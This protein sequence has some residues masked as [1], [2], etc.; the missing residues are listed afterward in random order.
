MMGGVSLFDPPPRRVA[1]FR[2]LNLGDLLCT[3]PA[4]RALRE[5]LPDASIS[6]IGLESARPVVARFGQY[7]D[8]L[9]LFP[10]DPAFPEQAV[11]SAELPDFYR[12]MAAR[13]FDLALQWHGS[14]ARSN[15]IVEAMAPRRWGGFVPDIV[16]EQ[17][18][19]L[20]AWPD[21]MPEIRRYLAQLAYM[22][23]PAA[24]DTLEFPLAATDEAEAGAVAQAERMVLHRSV[25]IHP[26]ARLASRRW[27]LSRY[28]EVARALSDDGWRIALTGSKDEQSLASDLQTL[29]GDVGEPVTNLCGKT[30]L[31][32]LAVLLRRGRL[33]ICNDTG[34]SHVAAAVGAP[35][36]VVASGSD[37][38]RWAPTNGR[39]HTVLHAPMAC[40]PCAHD[41]CPI[42]HPCAY[43]VTT[44][45][46]L[47]HARARLGAEGR[48]IPQRYAA[49]AN[50]PVAWHEPITGA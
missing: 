14:G 2:A 23:I 17:P 41:V 21:S 8:E 22:G 5:A 36:V 15:A 47:S 25:F 11:R 43:G 33:L 34:I 29:I 12:D 48:C 30:S 3:V 20:M 19:R 27:P 26:G 46:V 10:G 1:V 9:I 31:G 24:D 32:A 40:R 28:A 6:L 13:D 4:F 39:L 37:V 42:G 18:G 50:G 44:E 16:R 49:A 35:S 38:A 45:E 7:L